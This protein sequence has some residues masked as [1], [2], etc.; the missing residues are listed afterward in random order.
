MSV[1]STEQDLS[2]EDLAHEALVD[3]A[4]VSKIER[5]VIYVGLEIIEKSRKSPVYQRFA[6]S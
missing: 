5:G 3:R 6:Q 4:H 2:Q 1:P